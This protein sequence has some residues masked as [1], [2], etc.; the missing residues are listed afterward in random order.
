MAARGAIASRTISSRRVMTNED[1]G[2][3]YRH[4]LFG[5]RR[6]VRYH[7]HR[8]RFLDWISNTFKVATAVAGSAT[9]VSL[10][11][12]AGPWWPEAAAT[13]TAL[14]SAFD[15]VVAPGR[16]ARLHNDLARDFIGLEKDTL[17]AGSGLS[18][19]DLVALEARR[20]DIEANEPPHYRVLNMICHNELVRALGESP[21]HYVD[22]WCFQRWLANL[23]DICPG[24]LEK[25]ARV[26]AH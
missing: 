22:V 21:E 10:L 17:G 6:S 8:E 2:K 26:G 19:E 24:R 15:I 23:V 12:K 18:R 16:T 4:L 1:I 7:R 14:F 13:L 5:I 3:R 20:L 11:A 9:V 25:R